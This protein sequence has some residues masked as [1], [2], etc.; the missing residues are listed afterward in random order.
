MAA[1]VASGDDVHSGMLASEW[2]SFPIV[3]TPEQTE[4]LQFMVADAKAGIEQL[5][6]AISQLTNFGS[7]DEAAASITDIAAA[8]DKISDAFSFTSLK[9]VVGLIYDVA[10]R[11]AQVSDALMPE[12]LVRARA[13]HSLIEQHI[14]GLECGMEVKWS[15]GTLVSRTKRLLADKPLHPVVRGWHQGDVYRLLELDLVNESFDS[16]PRPESEDQFVEDGSVWVP[17]VAVT[18]RASTGSDQGKDSEKKPEVEQIIRVAA[19]TID[20]MLDLIS[21]LVLTKNRVF[22]LSRTMRLPG[23]LETRFEELTTA[24]DE[25]STLTG[26]LQLT[27][28]QARMQ[29]IT[30]LF[31]RYNRVVGDLAGLADKKVNLVVGGQ[32][33][34]IDKNLFDGLAEAMSQLLRSI[35]TKQ[36]KIPA[37]RIAQSKP[38]AA[39]ISL[40]AESQGAQ[41]IISIEHDGDLPDHAALAATAVEKNVCNA[42]ALDTLSD[43]ELFLLA[44]KPD[45]GDPQLSKVGTLVND[46]GG[47]LGIRVTADGLTR[48]EI[49]LPL[50]VAIVP[51]ILV[52]IGSES[53]AIPLQSVEEIIRCSDFQASTIHGKRVIRL[54]DSLLDVV[55]A[56][57]IIG[58]PAARPAQFAESADPVSP[59]NQPRIADDVDASRT[60][61]E[62][63]NTLCGCEVKPETAAQVKDESNA[64]GLVLSAG[65]MRAVLTVDRIIG[66]QEIV[67]KKLEGPIANIR[68]FAGATIRNDG[69]ISLIF[70]VAELLKAAS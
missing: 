44:F 1:L 54:R 51:A 50:S 61:A 66:K 24:A 60:L 7:R 4:S 11:S 63:V 21:Q 53:Y 42:E 56:T 30:K 37:D 69:T 64:F 62:D 32:A 65:F 47:K 34:M 20:S 5:S 58:E 22:N 31:E 48:I 68:C 8:L 27:M 26:N 3:F 40:D 10:K 57:S 46:L 33:A 29:P 38:E 49:A 2:G 17:P 43:N 45:F 70:D 41:I 39:T 52:G 59:P 67:I 9:I 12:V 13:I 28:M 35:V 16:P 23:S 14:R 15:L 36:V 19:T 6:G 55:S 25:L 18:D